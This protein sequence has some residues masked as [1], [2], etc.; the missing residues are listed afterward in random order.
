VGLLWID[1]EGHEVAVLAGA[2]ALTQRAKPVAFELAGAAGEAGLAAL[3]AALHGVYRSLVDLHDPGL[4]QR[5][6]GALDELAAYY[7][8]DGRVKTDVLVLP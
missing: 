5:P 1:V 4:N 7:A 6:I 8:Q 2:T 3:R